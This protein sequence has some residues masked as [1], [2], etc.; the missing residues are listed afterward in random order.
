MKYVFPVV[1]LLA[2]LTL[3][4]CANAT[5]DAATPSAP[6]SSP[7]EPPQTSA[8]EGDVLERDN[9]PDDESL[10][11]NE[12]GIDM[13]TYVALLTYWDNEMSEIDRYN[14][15]NLNTPSSSIY[16]PERAANEIF[17]GLNYYLDRNGFEMVAG[18]ADFI[19]TWERVYQDR[20]NGKYPC[21]FTSRGEDSGNTISCDVLQQRNLQ[22]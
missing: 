10:G 15:C 17:S 16:Q 5:T 1:A 9:R 11:G 2:A 12:S 13:G 21:D 3:V 4:G 7:A 8:P 14:A 22:D 19:A 20:C 6:T 18:G